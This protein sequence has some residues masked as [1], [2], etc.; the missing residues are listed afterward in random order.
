MRSVVSGLS[1]GRAAAGLL[2]LRVV[3]AATLLVEAGGPNSEPIVVK[4]LSGIAGI[5]IL[6]GFRASP[7]AILAAILAL[8]PL[9]E[10]QTDLVAHVLLATLAA[11]IALLG[12]GAWSLDARFSGWKRIDIPKRR[13]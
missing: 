9:F 4:A 2:L 5:A 1:A 13:E 11:A 7:A 10:G 3:C 6:I 12:P 8:W